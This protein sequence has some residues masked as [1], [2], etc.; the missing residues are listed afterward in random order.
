[1]SASSFPLGG[2]VHSKYSAAAAN[3]RVVFFAGLPA[4]G[5][6]F[7]LKQFVLLAH[8]AGREVHVLQWDI[9]RPAFEWSERAAA[10]PQIDGVTHPVVRTSVGTWVRNALA[11]W[12]TAHDAEAIVVGELPLVGGRLIELTRE[13]DDACEP[14]LSS[15]ATVTFVPVPSNTVRAEIE[16]ARVESLANPEHDRE[17]ED[18]P[19]SVVTGTWEEIYDVGTRLG[20]CEPASDPPY[21]AAIYAAVYD[22]LL[23]HRHRDIIKISRLSPR[24]GSVYD[25][26]IQGSELVPT[27]GEIDETMTRVEANPSMLSDDW[28]GIE[29]P[30]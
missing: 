4:V 2:E 26:E 25:F 17:V 10:Y 9:A 16:H 22:H 19:I 8:D 30:I 11:K 6:S 28:A 21:D 27:V 13:I 23:R 24:S 15:E 20:I 18:A 1:M 29:A 5:K 12:H 3:A 14:L 7:H